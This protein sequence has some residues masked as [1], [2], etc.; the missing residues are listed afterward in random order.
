V[1]NEVTAR[2]ADG[3][4]LLVAALAATTTVETTTVGW[5]DD[6]AEAAE[7][8][9]AAA[10]PCAT[11]AAEEGAGWTGAAAVFDAAGAVLGLHVS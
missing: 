5:E 2:E 10:D 7:A 4:P 6:D 9:G 3:D 1:G 8:T 11:D